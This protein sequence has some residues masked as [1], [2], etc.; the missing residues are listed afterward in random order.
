[1]SDFFRNLA[2]DLKD[3]D[4]TIAADGRG[5]AEFSGTVDTGSGSG[6]NTFLSVYGNDSDPFSHDPGGTH[7]GI[8]GNAVHTLDDVIVTIAGNKRLFIDSTGWAAFTSNLSLI[9][10]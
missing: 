6:N 2:E 3:E 10:I 5:S 4:T 8:Q 9:H 7:V 1:M